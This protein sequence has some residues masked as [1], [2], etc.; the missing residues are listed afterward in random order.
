VDLKANLPEDD[1]NVDKAQNGFHVPGSIKSRMKTEGGREDW[2]NWIYRFHD[3]AGRGE[4][5]DLPVASNGTLVRPT[6]YVERSPRKER[7]LLTLRCSFR[8]GAT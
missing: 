5:S 3:E 4:R 2:K 7:E 6:L 8:G 1:Y